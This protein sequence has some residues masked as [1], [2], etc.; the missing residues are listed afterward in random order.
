ML[1]CA[2][3]FKEIFPM[4]RERDVQYYCC[5]FEED[6]E[7]VEKVCSILE[8]FWATTNI[9]LGSDYPTS[10][11]F[12]QEVKR[13]KLVLDSKAN[14]DDDFVRAMVRKMKFKFDEYWGECNLL[15]AVVAVLDPRQKMTAIE[16]CFSKLFPPS[17]AQQNIE[18]VRNAVFELYNEYLQ[19]NELRE[20]GNRKD[21][22]VSSSSVSESSASGSGWDDFDEYVREYQTGPPQESELL[23]YLEKG[24]I[25]IDSSVPRHEFDCLN[26]WKNSKLTF[27][28]LSKMAADILAIPITTVTS[29]ATFSAGT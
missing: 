24:P 21:S 26:W 29:E 2:I 1:N 17:E 25:K 16:Y 13:I 11:L 27:P 9:I 20:G 3:K 28:I 4:Y 5:P 10:N 14:D 8:T 7:K 12:L 15:M 6:W 23:I 18:K 22:Q 19:A